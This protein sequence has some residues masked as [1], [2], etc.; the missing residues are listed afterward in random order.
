[1]VSAK[2]LSAIGG[3]EYN[4]AVEDDLRLGMTAGEGHVDPRRRCGRGREHPDAES[5]V[6]GADASSGH[7]GDATH[8]ISDRALANA[9]LNSAVSSAAIR[10]LT[11]PHQP[12]TI[13][14]HRPR[15]NQ[16]DNVPHRKPS[17]T[18]SFER[19]SSTRILPV[20]EG[21]P[22]LPKPQLRAILASRRTSP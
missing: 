22:R 15:S 14:R 13:G 9:R 16:L 11:K 6:V 18:E 17:R 3:W 10:D 4:G 8:N 19:L 21:F 2:K 20:Q 7:G 5:A 1:M 12:R